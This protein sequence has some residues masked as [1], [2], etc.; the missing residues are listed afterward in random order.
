MSTNVGEERDCLR[1][2]LEF[3]EGVGAG[4][5]VGELRRWLDAH[6]VGPGRMTKVRAVHEPLVGT[7]PLSGTY[8]PAPGALVVGPEQLAQLLD[9]ARDRV[10]ETLRAFALPNSDDRFLSAAIYA[11]RVERTRVGARSV[12]VAKPSEADRLSDIVLALFATDILMDRA[13]HE[14]LLCVCDRCGRVSFEPDAT[15][16]HGCSDH[17]PRRGARSG[18]VRKLSSAS[19]RPGHARRRSG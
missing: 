2:G 9:L 6:L 8:V 17:V 15:T 5:G 7:L 3:V 1:A 12:W 10:V 4:F 13:F 18:F 14:R 11:G 16:R 19:E